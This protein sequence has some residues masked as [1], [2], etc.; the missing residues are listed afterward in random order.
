M[1]P[2]GWFGNKGEIQE[3]FIWSVD[4]E[5]LYQ[6]TQAAYNLNPTKLRSKTQYD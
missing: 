2:N 6:M 4:P 3:D 5:A 1:T